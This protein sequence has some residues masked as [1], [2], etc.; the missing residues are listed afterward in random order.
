MKQCP[1]CAEE[2]QD[3]AIKCKHCSSDL[4]NSKAPNGKINSLVCKQC[5]G[6]M[7]KKTVNTYVGPAFIAIILGFFILVVWSGLLGSLI[8]IVGIILA[9]FSKKYWVCKK[10]SFKIEKY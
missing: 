3:E 10:C 9:A 1:F 2:I 6:E 8:I 7:A 4:P 5:G